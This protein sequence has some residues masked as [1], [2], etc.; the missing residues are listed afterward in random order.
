[1]SA[2][3]FAGFTC[4]TPE[5]VRETIVLDAVNPTDAVFEATHHPGRVLRRDA[6]AGVG[7]DLLTENDVLDDLLRPS[8]G[9]LLMPIVGESGSGKSHLV[10][11]LRPRIPL[12]DD[13]GK[14]RHVVYIPKYET[15]LR[16]VIEKIIEGM[17]GESFDRLRTDM[18][19]ATDSLDE[20]GA[21]ERLLLALSVH[22]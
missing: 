7:G 11:W 2:H 22:T 21:A 18:R 19:Q 17:E 6:E 9:L 16:Q 20:N 4:W 15:T 10:R 13:R 8:D 1:M 5:W 3:G 14:K 12:I